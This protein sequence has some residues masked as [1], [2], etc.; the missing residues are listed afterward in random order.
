MNGDTCM[1]SKRL[2]RCKIQV[3]NGSGANSVKGS[4]SIEQSKGDSVGVILADILREAVACLAWR[5]MVLPEHVSSMC[6][7]D[8]SNSGEHKPPATRSTQG[9]IVYIDIRLDI[10]AMHIDGNAGL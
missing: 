4:C 5:L 6:S 7:A 8:V 10:P 9:N 2:G 3:G 1:L